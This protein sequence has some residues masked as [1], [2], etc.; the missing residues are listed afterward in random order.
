MRVLLIESVPGAGRDQAVG[1]EA[2]GHQVVR[3]HEMGVPSFPCR[4]V[5]GDCPVETGPVDVALGVRSASPA[6][7]SGEEQGV[8]CA[9][10]HRIPVVVD[11]D[12]G[13]PYG[14]RVLDAGHDPVVACEAAQRAPQF[15]HAAAI[16]DAVDAHP[17]LA[18]DG[19]RVSVDV[20]RRAPDLRVRVLVPDGLGPDLEA[21]VAN[22][23]ASA[24]RRYDRSARVI[25]VSLE[26]PVG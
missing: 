14:A 15:G 8:T 25:D 11:A 12:A 18:A 1:L 23:A 7:P 19:I 20:R 17:L 16:R 6:E 22:R 10:R 5:D 26:R 3:C 9:L 13:H 24:A 4:G 21:A 2:A